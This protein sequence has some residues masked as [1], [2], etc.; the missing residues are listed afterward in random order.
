MRC[1]IRWTLIGEWGHKT[2]SFSRPLDGHLLEISQRR[3]QQL[4]AERAG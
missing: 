4:A 3:Q 1:S 2:R